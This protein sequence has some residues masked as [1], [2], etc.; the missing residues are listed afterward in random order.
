MTGASLT[1][2]SECG[3]PGKHT[4]LTTPTCN[5]HQSKKIQHNYIPRSDRKNL[6]NLSFQEQHSQHISLLRFILF[7]RL[8][9]LVMFCPR[10]MRLAAHKQH[11]FVQAVLTKPIVLAQ[12]SISTLLW[13]QRHVATMAFG[14]K[15]M[16]PTWGRRGA[17]QQRS[18]FLTRQA[19]CLKLNEILYDYIQQ[20]DMMCP[21]P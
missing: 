5:W 1:L 6:R 10:M 20:F 4:F 16:C 15:Q 18:N 9:A 7:V 14:R 21:P 19:V 2:L 17:G 3:S 13:E 12:Y 8:W 11:N